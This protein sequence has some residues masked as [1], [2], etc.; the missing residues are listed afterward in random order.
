MPDNERFD[1]VVIGA[2]PAGEVAV[3]R[4]HAH[5]L[6][7]ALVERELVG[8]EC[9][10]WACIPSKTL[11]RPM[12]ARGEAARAKGV[13]TPERRWDEAVTYR[14]YMIR[15][16]DDARQVEDYERDGVRVYKGQAKL[17]GP[18]QVEIDEETLI[19]AARVIIATGSHTRIPDIPGLAE[20]GYW[21]NRE[22]TTLTEI[23]ESVAIIGGGPVGIELAQLLTRFGA[24]VHLVE[25]GER[26][27]EREDPRVGELVAEALREDGIELHLNTEIR[28][29]SAEQGDRELDLGAGGRLRVREVIVASGRSPS[30][31]DLGLETVGIHPYG[32]GIK[33]DERCRAGDQVWA[34]G[35][36][37]GV[38]PFTHV[39]KY[40]ARIACA[41]IAGEAVA[42]DY[43]AIP[44]VVFSDPEVAAVGMTHAHAHAEELDV[45]SASVELPEAISRPWTYESDPRG[46]LSVMVDRRRRVV[47]GA[48]AVAPLAGEWIH[49]AALAVKAAISIDVLRDTVAQ[50]PTYTEG[51]LE[52]LS[53]VEM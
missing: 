37:T 41:D 5:G 10:Y 11:L 35:D 48:W 9:A 51:F 43:S 15:N 4:L 49:Y 21:T 36:V 23:P 39:A 28:S 52:A 38:M 25:A 12:E 27:I 47:V 50:F 17:R 40:Q 44:R 20:A 16:L 26:L 33:I 32:D 6:R 7:T 14:D 24:E 31:T 45:V 22:A 19:V 34:I 18:G 3:E 8:G 53:Q 46:E 1:A 42:A 2:G 30:V 13:A 29:V